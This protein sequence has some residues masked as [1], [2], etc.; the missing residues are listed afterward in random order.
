MVVPGWALVAINFIDTRASSL[1]KARSDIRFE[2]KELLAFTRRSHNDDDTGI[3][4]IA[5]N[6]IR[7]PRPNRIGCFYQITATLV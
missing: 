1:D 3:E 7:S 2:H 5:D 6:P 4:Q